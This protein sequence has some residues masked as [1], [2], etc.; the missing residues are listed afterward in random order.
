[1]KNKFRKTMHDLVYCIWWVFIICSVLYLLIDVSYRVK[2]QRAIKEIQLEKQ[3][4][5]ENGMQD[6]EL[7]ATTSAAE[8]R[9][10]LEEYKSL[11]KKNNDLYGWITI[12]GTD[13]DFPVMFTPK[14][15]N[16]YEDKNLEKE[17]CK[18][19][20]WWVWIDG[21]TTQDTENTIIYGH[22]MRYGEMFGSLKK[23]KKQ[24]FYQKYKYIQFDTLYERGT[25]E[26][27]SVVTT[28]YYEEDEGYYQF[29]DHVE[30]DSAKE[31]QEYVDNAKKN[32]CYPIET[33]AEFG[34]CLIT[35]TTCDG[36]NNEILLIIAKR[37]D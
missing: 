23:Y 35:L 14:D 25:Y 31:F 30:L 37:I 6:L 13:I 32:E 36:Y 4:A 1:M 28:K 18:S 33:T 26:I 12:E 10:I 2:E 22:N 21:R 24:D 27:I 19:G 8:D 15:P 5:L 17:V 7:T 29:Y 20:G 9:Q 3:K 11:Y 16:F 34:D